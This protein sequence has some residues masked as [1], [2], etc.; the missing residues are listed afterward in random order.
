LTTSLLT[1]NSKH[2]DS[3]RGGLAGMLEHRPIKERFERRIREAVL[4][5]SFVAALPSS[6][7]AQSIVS[8]DDS[9]VGV[10]STTSAKLELTY[11]RPTQRTMARNY[12]FDTF[13]IYPFAGAAVAAGISQF[14]NAPPEWHQGVEGYSKRFGS[15]FG[16]AAVGTTA[17]YGLAEALREDTMYYRC[18]CRG[19]F[20]RLR[21]AAFSTLT[22]RRGDD[23]HRVFSVPALIAPY[24]GSMTAVYGW[25][26]DRYGAKDGF[27]MGNYSLLVNMGGNVALEFLYG[28]PHSLLSRMH[29]KNTHGAPDTGPNP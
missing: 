8:T 4:L 21:H 9:A 27:R 29:L 24:A 5:L 7:G 16:I 17:R 14:G 18:E 23:G 15:D 13:G 1:W 25:Y 28:G 22:A 12:A 3:C 2:L 6:M 26:P 20:P 19:V 11:Q 10:K